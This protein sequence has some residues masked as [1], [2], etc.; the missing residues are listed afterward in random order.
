MEDRVNNSK[1]DLIV[2]SKVLK[3]GISTVLPCVNPGDIRIELSGIYIKID[4]DKM[5][6]V[7]TNGIKLIEYILPINSDIASKE[8][9]L[10]YKSAKDLLKILVPKQDASMIF[11]DKTILFKC[12]DNVITGRLITDKKFPNYKAFLEACDRVITIPRKDFTSS[13]KNVIALLDICDNYR[14]TLEAKGKTFNLKSDGKIRVEHL[15]DHELEHQLDVDVN[16]EFLLSLL[17]KIPGDNLDICFMEG[18]N[19]I[20]FREQGNDNLTSL[21]SI[22]RRKSETQND[23]LDS[24]LMIRRKGVDRPTNDIKEKL[25]ASLR[26]ISIWVGESVDLENGEELEYFDGLID[27]AGRLIEEM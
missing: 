4:N 5:T 10:Q 6:F 11:A 24:E 14:L 23:T 21:L 9:I 16:G 20:I 27:E 1:V 19:F 15:L 25:R 7:G 8:F 2:E 13:V 26:D 17:N 22:V 12:N 3:E 18:K